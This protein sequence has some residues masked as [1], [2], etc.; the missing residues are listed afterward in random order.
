MVFFNRFLELQ[1]DFKTL[2]FT[3]GKMQKHGVPD[4]LLSKCVYF[5]RLWIVKGSIKNQNPTETHSL[6]KVF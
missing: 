5:G 3:V 1:H 4:V 6:E 2:S